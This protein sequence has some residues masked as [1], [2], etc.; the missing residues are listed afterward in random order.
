MHSQL[1]SFGG[2]H[3]TV[4]RSLPTA[5]RDAPEQA[6]EVIVT[7]RAM[8]SEDT[9]SLEFGRSN[10]QPLPPFTAGA[11]IDLRLTPNLV[12]QYSLCNDPA[13]R[14]RYRLGIQLAAPSRGGSIAACALQV[15]D[16]VQISSPRNHFPL[17]ERAPRSILVG[18]GI[19]ITPLISMA[20]RLSA[21]NANF[22]LHYCVRNIGRAGFLE[23]LQTSSFADHLT[24]HYSSGPEQQRFSVATTLGEPQDGTHIYVCGSTRFIGWVIGDA[25]SRGWKNLHKEYFNAEVD[26][27]GDVFV[28]KTARTGLSVEIP[29]DKTISQVLQEHGI[30]LP[31]SCE[32]GVCGA[33]LTPVLEG[34]PDHRDVYQTP[35]E[36]ANDSQIAVCCSRSKS[37]VLKLDI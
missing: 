5:A 6:L 37:P 10:H 25:T 22:E 7:D 12:R 34:V 2:T 31:L 35:E 36:H 33:C 15:G 14:H 21:L 30:K 1:A 9:I 19:G 24:M 32:Q 18:G 13:E 20:H 11:H 29:A 23:E 16:R 28:V 26:T 27:R 8:Q 17:L 4:Q 3:P